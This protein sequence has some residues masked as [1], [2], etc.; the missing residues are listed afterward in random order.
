MTKSPQVRRRPSLVCRWNEKLGTVCTNESPIRLRYD[1]RVA[2]L[3][4]T[5][6]HFQHNDIFQ[7]THKRLKCPRHV[8]D[9]RPKHK[10]K[11]S[12][13]LPEEEEEEEEFEEEGMIDE[14]E[15]NWLP[16]TA[17]AS[18]PREVKDLLEIAEAE[19]PEDAYAPLSPEEE[20][21]ELPQR[22]EGSDTTE[23]ISI[24]TVNNGDD[25][26][27]QKEVMKRQMEEERRKAAELKL[28]EK[29][30][31]KLQLSIEKQKM[32]EKLAAAMEL[33]RQR[34]RKEMEEFVRQQEL[35]RLVQERD[36]NIML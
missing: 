17:F 12:P 16:L 35:H 18:A 19:M 3:C 27:R 15:P 25:Y 20:S 32:K 5:P 33:E 6:S 10:K 8:W 21:A 11:M 23:S 9:P 1:S 2:P 14:E 28:Q 34:K 26:R 7:V 30:Q 29:H 36:S 13:A 4:K 31:L 24:I 22:D